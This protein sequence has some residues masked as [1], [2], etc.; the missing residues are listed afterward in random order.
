MA[1]AP[2]GVARALTLALLLAG[3]LLAACSDEGP[4]S[5][6]STTTTTAPDDGPPAADERRAV[7]GA[8]RVGH[9]RGRAHQRAADRR[10]LDADRSDLPRPVADD[11]GGFEALLLVTGDPVLVYNAYVDAAEALGM[12][13][14]R[15]WL[16]LRVRVD[17]LRPAHGRPVR[18]RGAV[19]RGRA[20]RRSTG[21]SSC[22]TPRLHYEPPGSVDLDEVEPEQASPPTSTPAVVELPDE[23]P[24]PGD[25]WSQQV[26]GGGPPLE[27]ADGTMLAGAA[28]SLPVRH[29]GLVGGRRRWTATPRRRSRT[30]PSSSASTTRPSAPA[31]TAGDGRRPR[32]GAG[33]RHPAAAR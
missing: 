27:L 20:P 2:H 8:G 1:R 23:V 19:D 33:G 16:H 17:H 7:P 26:G 14:G 28:G 29:A 3:S 25:D 9:V 30:T 12:Q 5:T 24:E 32:A 18:R 4:E 6:R 31:T 22:R 15:A 21:A 11:P 10:G 13:S